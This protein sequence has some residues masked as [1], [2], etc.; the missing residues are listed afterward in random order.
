MKL[1]VLQKVVF[2]WIRTHA[3]GSTCNRKQCNINARFSRAKKPEIVSLRGMLRKNCLWTSYFTLS[4][5]HF[6]FLFFPFSFLP[7]SLLPHLWRTIV[8]QLKSS[9]LD[10][11]ATLPMWAALYGPNSTLPPS[12]NKGRANHGA[13]L[14]N[15]SNATEESSLLGHGSH[16][17]LRKKLPLATVEF[18]PKPPKR[19]EL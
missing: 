4:F 8:P 3:S 2:S 9:A 12:R 18:E 7:S 10:H 1:T 17:S 6:S 16:K 11:S 15:S 14:R 19:L 13:S 5:L